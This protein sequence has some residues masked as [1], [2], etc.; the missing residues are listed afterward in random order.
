MVDEVLTLGRGE[1][2]ARIPLFSIGDYT[3]CEPDYRQ[4]L[5]WA[6]QLKMEPLDL[7]NTLLADKPPKWE[8]RAVLTKFE[9][10][11]ILSL[12]WDLDKLPISDLIYIE[13]LKIQEI[14]MHSETQ[15][16][17]SLMASIF[18]EPKPPKRSCRKIRLSLPTLLRL[19]HGGCESETIVLENVPNLTEL[20]CH[21]SSLEKL[22]LFLTPNL[23]RLYCVRNNLEDLDLSHV[24][25]LIELLCWSNQFT[26]LDLSNVPKL[27]GLACGENQ[28]IKLDLSRVP[29]L[30]TL[31]CRRNQL[32]GLDLSQVPNLTS[33]LCGENRIT[34]L[35]LSDVPNLT[36]LWCEKNDIAELD[37]RPLQNLVE[38]EYDSDKTRLIQRPDQNF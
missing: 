38:L 9:N 34:K 29:N 8:R 17:L 7:L 19:D 30:T 22:N 14:K 12:R 18:N 36:K 10:G 24:P 11:R 13:G 27:F 26:S 6:N 31:S 20:I 4:I 2:E 5:L 35:D 37:I 16:S 25:N 33:L 1:A 28:L 23:T 32:S 15:A 21:G 3:W